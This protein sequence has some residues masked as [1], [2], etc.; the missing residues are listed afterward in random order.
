MSYAEHVKVA[1]SRLLNA[2]IGGQYDQM[3]S[4]RAWEMSPKSRKWDLVRSVLDF[5]F[6]WDNGHCKLN[7]DWEKGLHVCSDEDSS[8]KEQK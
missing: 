1:I 3:L 5:V 6:Y 4:S 7:Y 2:V 8:T